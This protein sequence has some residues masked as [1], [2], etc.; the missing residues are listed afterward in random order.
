M[1]G[2]CPARGVCVC[3][4]VRVREV[5]GKSICGRLGFLVE[6]VLFFVTHILCPVCLEPHDC[7]W[8]CFVLGCA[9]FVPGASV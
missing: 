2:K 3:V 7:V 1:I 5:V 4:R 6:K 8:V 9:N